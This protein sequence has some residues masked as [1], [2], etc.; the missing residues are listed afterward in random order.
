VKISDVFLVD[1]TVASNAATPMRQV[2]GKRL[3]SILGLGSEY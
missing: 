1:A 2:P 3:V